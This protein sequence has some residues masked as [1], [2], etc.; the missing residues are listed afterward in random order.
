MNVNLDQLDLRQL[1]ALLAIVDE[2]S[3][4]RAAQHLGFTQSA[5]SQQVA[6]LERAVGSPVF[7]RMGGP[8]RSKLTPIGVVLVTHTRTVLAQI[9]TAAEEIESLRAGTSGRLTV[10]TFQSV[11]VKVLPEIVRRFREAMPGIEVRLHESEDNIELQS[12]VLS[13]ELDLSFV[14]GPTELDGLDSIEVFRDPFVAVLPNGSLDSAGPVAMHELADQALVGQQDSACQDLIDRGL[15]HHG[16]VAKY[17]FRSNDNG[18]MQNMVKAGMG[19]AVMPLLAVETAD[20]DI[21]I[22]PLEPAL[23]ARSI[24]LAIPRGR[25]PS[26]ATQAFIDLAIDVFNRTQTP[27]EE[28]AS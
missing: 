4:G 2:G 18:A 27:T 14:V 17:S 3:F 21:E 28:L 12:R 22:R 8:K 13:D 10:G 26:T 16:L 25:T 9:L 11:S 20:P 6:A 23:E 15:A 7:D 24:V 5:V 1:R 19:P